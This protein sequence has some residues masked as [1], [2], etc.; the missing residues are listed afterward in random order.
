[1][2]ISSFET[3]KILISCYRATKKDINFTQIKAK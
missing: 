2:L 1:M 3:V